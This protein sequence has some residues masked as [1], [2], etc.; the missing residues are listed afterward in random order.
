MIPGLD[1]EV[2]LTGATGKE[3]GTHT[4]PLLWHPYLYHYGRNWII[5]GDGSYSL[6]GRFPTPQ[7]HR[8]DKTN[9][10]RSEGADVTFRNVK[11]K[12]GLSRCAPRGRVTLSL[13]PQKNNKQQAAPKGSLSHIAD[14]RT[15]MR[16]LAAVGSGSG[17]LAASRAGA[18]PGI[19]GAR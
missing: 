1:I 6:R 10:K 14:V 13:L 12:T 2:T 8:H 3:I 7:S 5:P 16:L 18:R 4:Q 9:G 11:L 19:A 17:R 15:A